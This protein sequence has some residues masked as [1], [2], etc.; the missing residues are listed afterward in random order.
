[1]RMIALIES[2]D[3]HELVIYDIFCATLFLVLQS[4]SEAFRIAY[5]QVH[6]EVIVVLIHAHWHKTFVEVSC[7]KVIFLKIM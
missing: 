5:L 6:V 3:A 7:E 2:I 1:M 4:L